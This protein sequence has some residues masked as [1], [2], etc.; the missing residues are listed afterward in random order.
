MGTPLGSFSSS[1]DPKRAS[2]DSHD[3]KRQMLAPPEIR[4]TVDFEHDGQRLLKHIRSEFGTATTSVVVPESDDHHSVWWRSYL[5]G[6][7]LERVSGTASP[8]RTVDLFCGPGGLS[9]GFGRGVHELGLTHQPVAAVDEDAH[10][11]SVYAHNHRP[12]LTS[13]E[14]VSMLVDYQVRGN[15]ETAS[16]V[17][18][19]EL[20]DEAWVTLA[21]TVEAVVAGPPCQG[22]SNLNNHSR[23]SDPRNALY[24]TV[25]AIAVALG[26]PIVVIENVPSVLHDHSGV[27]QTATK[28]LETSGYHITAGVL[29]ADKMGW[30][31]RRQRYFLVARRDTQ[32]IPLDVVAEALASEERS[33]MWA[34]GA[35]DQQED[36]GYMT[37]TAQLS[38][39]NVRRIDWLFDNDEYDLTLHE[40]PDCHKDGTTYTSVYGRMYPDRPAPTITTGFFTPGRGRF[41]HPTE[42]RTI[43]AREAA[44]LQGFP[45]TYRFSPR[46]D[47]T[48][49]KLHLS[50]W[51]GDAVPM[52]LGYTAALSALLPGAPTR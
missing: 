50:K 26:A 3:R 14:S 34:I 52:P 29:H 8:I 48:P 44:R 19:P 51:I 38:D 5:E 41:T 25:P 2:P 12:R 37:E 33:V 45:D 6:K 4:P 11:L 23:R 47:S 22:H 18:E 13:S 35:L 30:P 15:A 27:V 46:S 36:H 42:R 20:I 1:F 9:L 39:E 28:L 10:A 49:P 32:P 7:N 24:L 31:Q 21:G 17:Y 16:F 43:N 40:R